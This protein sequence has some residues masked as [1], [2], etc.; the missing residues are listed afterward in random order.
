MD[1]ECAAMLK[2]YCS[3]FKISQSDALY[4]FARSAI[5]NHYFH[6]KK[7]ESIFHLRQRK[8]DKR[9]GKYCFGFGCLS[10][11]HTAMCTAGLYEGYF[12]VSEPCTH[13]Y[14]KG[15]LTE[16]AELIKKYRTKA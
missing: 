9:A 14:K 16:F 5:Q 6:C 1:E 7:V 3:F 11:Q 13:L 4:L 8:L 2:E 12:E 15:F 10:C